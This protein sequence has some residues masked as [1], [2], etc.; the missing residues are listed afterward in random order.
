MQGTVLTGTFH[1]SCAFCHECHFYGML[2]E[3]P[4]LCPIRKGHLLW[5]KIE[6]SPVAENEAYHFVFLRT[7]LT[8]SNNKRYLAL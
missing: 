5:E 1:Y 7:L 8:H 3:G 2:L 6:V 4:R